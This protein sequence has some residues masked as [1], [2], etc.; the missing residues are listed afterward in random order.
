MRKLLLFILTFLSS[1]LA[2]GQTKYENEVKSFIAIVL[3][4]E[5]TY[6][7][8]N[9]IE[10][11]LELSEADPFDF[12]FAFLKKRID[13]IASE[14]MLRT[15]IGKMHFDTILFV[16]N[17]DK[18][19]YDNEKKN[20][21]KFLSRDSIFEI[22]NP[23]NKLAI[24]KSVDTYA[25][26]NKL[27]LSDLFNADFISEDELNQIFTNGGG[28]TEFENK[29]RNGFLKMTLPI[30]TE[31][32]EYAYFEWSYHC[33]GLCGYGYSGLYKKQNGKWTPVKIYMKWMS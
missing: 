23:F 5:Y 13:T 33:G 32:Y 27:N 9:F 18:Y 25:Q 16:S 31:D 30:F 21:M 29:H 1:N 26:H 17:P 8:Q 6:T 28:W 11:S 15:D 14:Y 19:H 20:L 3:T 4:D 22:K 10:D 2:F 24:E 7:I 12:E